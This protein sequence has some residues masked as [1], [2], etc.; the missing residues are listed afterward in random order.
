MACS[1]VWHLGKYAF[2]SKMNDK[3]KESNISIINVFYEQEIGYVK[4]KLRTCSNFVVVEQWA[5]AMLQVGC[6]RRIGLW[7]VWSAL[8]SYW[9]KPMWYW[10]SSS[11]FPSMMRNEAVIFGVGL[12]LFMDHRWMQQMVNPLCCSSKS[13]M[14]WL[15]WL[16]VG[17]L[18]FVQT[19][20]KTV[21]FQEPMCAM[22]LQWQC[23]IFN[24]GRGENNWEVGACTDIVK[25][26]APFM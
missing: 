1:H 24:W 7:H 17:M 14:S 4:K 20:W 23:S 26:T 19:N 25:K 5:Y 18:G 2:F 6:N 21:N 13:G 3:V 12:F 9:G 8:R 11:I 22:L 10:T 15:L 16:W